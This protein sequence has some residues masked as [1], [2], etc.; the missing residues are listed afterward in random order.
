MSEDSGSSAGKT[1]LWII[2]RLLY[3]KHHCY[4][5]DRDWW[6]VAGRAARTWPIDPWI[7]GLA[8]QHNPVV[9]AGRANGVRFTISSNST[10]LS[11]VLQSISGKHLSG[12]NNL[13]QAD[14]AAQG[15]GE[16]RMQMWTC[17]SRHGF[18]GVIFCCLWIWRMQIN[19]FMQE[20][21]GEVGESKNGRVDTFWKCYSM[22]VCVSVRWVWMAFQDTTKIIH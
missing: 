1:C 4:H 22:H 14:I 3:L 13:W 19:A 20:A 16:A 15:T 7:R 17:V 9:R 2:T 21:E 6:E 10:G 11:L 8:E 12:K 18:L 5:N